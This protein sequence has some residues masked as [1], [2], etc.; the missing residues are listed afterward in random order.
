LRPL[1]ASGAHTESTVADTFRSGHASAPTWREAA[2][3]CLRQ[4]RPL[5]GA[6]NLGFVYL[7]DAFAQQSHE[8]L[9]FLREQEPSLHWVGTVG[10]GICASGTE[11][12]AE[13][14]IAVLT[15]AFPEESFRVFSPIVS[16]LWPFE[17]AHRKWCDQAQPY[18][19]VV[20]GDPRNH[21]ITELVVQLAECMEN[22]FLVGGLASSRAGYL[23]IADGVADGGL[24]G[25]LFSAAVPVTT[26]LTQGCSPIG[27]RR[28]V[29][30][31]EENIIIE[32]DG[33]PAL[34]VFNEDIGEVL[35]R[36]LS[37]VAGYIF[38]GLPV[39]RS[40][41]GDYV[42][43]SLVALDPKNRVLA[44]DEMVSDGDVMLFCRRDARAAQDDLM[45]MLHEIKGSLNGTPRGGVYHSCIARGA[46]LF[47]PGSREL[48]LIEQ[49]LG[50]FPLAGFFGNGEICHDRLYSYTGVLTL[51]L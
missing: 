43:R 2:E 42:V 7:T 48:K 30:S 3:A 26:R 47:G 31:S 50:H 33:R 35:A 40:D 41:T 51:F 34:D 5:P 24:S 22:G 1:A 12:Y 10:M 49:E 16:T 25:V 39:A 9:D 14:A 29:T 23:H 36:D 11:Y 32:L 45:R 15:G 17:R 20:H 46:N 27:P 38:A 18:F 37:R 21:S 6:S 4:L 8:V 13:P 19:G 44:I 28:E